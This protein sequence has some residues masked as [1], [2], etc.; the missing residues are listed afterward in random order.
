SAAGFGVVQLLEVQG[1]LSLDKLATASRSAF[2]AGLESA[3]GARDR[4]VRCNLRLVW[5][6]ARRY[7]FSGIPLVD[8]IQEGSI[9]LIR[10]AD[11]YDHTRGF[12]FS[13]Y[14]TWWI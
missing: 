10:A 9:G 13:T 5:S 4:L 14:A 11:R 1:R 3:M 12:R 7:T 8:L 2:R 6:I